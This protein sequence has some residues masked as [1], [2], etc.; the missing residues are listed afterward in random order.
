MILRYHDINHTYYLLPAEMRFEDVP[1]VQ[2]AGFTYWEAPGETEGT[3]AWYA[4]CDYT[5]LNLWGTA[6]LNL[7]TATF[8]RL[9]PHFERVHESYQIAPVSSGAPEIPVPDGLD[10][11][12]FQSAGISTTSQRFMGGQKS[13]LVGDAMGLGKTIQAIGVVNA[14][15]MAPHRVL[16]VCPASLRINWQRELDKW[17]LNAAPATAV[18]KRSQPIQH[19][20]PLV[21][22]YELTLN[23][24]WLLYLIS[25]QW[26][27]VIFDEA[28]YLKNVEAKRT[29]A[30]LDQIAPQ[31]RHTL[32]LSG[33]PI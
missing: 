1:A 29:K 28:Q 22:S 24:R 33:T 11:M 13:I 20:G 5:A 8:N 6:D 23:Q 9:S 27:I 30:C 16:V 31:A 18:L 25:Q 2:Q 21:V 7:D 3:G 12:D 32:L 14:M 26:D 15:S 10:Y 17:M 19:M 4:S